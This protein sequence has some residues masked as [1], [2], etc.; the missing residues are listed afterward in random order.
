MD[1]LRTIVNDLMPFIETVLKH[2]IA[3]GVTRG[4]VRSL[5]QRL[6][7]NEFCKKAFD[8]STTMKTP[9]RLHLQ[10]NEGGGTAKPW[11]NRGMK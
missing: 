6:F 7:L 3:G 4:R 5:Y 8:N 1:Y 9:A 11:V 10:L 2:V